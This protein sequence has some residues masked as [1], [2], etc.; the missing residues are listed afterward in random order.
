MTQADYREAD[1]VGRCV[2]DFRRLLG[3]FGGCKQR[4]Q[5]DPVGLRL[6]C[7]RG[8]GGKQWS[9]RTE[10]AVNEATPGDRRL[11]GTGGAIGRFEARGADVHRST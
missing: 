6:L 10:R 9:D 4:R 3:R 5:L 7:Q 1:P 8:P 11:R 2:K